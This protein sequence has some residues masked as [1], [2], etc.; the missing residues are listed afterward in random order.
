MLLTLLVI[1]GLIVVSTA[2]GSAVLAWVPG[3]GR[4]LL[5]ASPLGLAALVLWLSWIGLVVPPGS[6]HAL[7]LTVAAL[8][9]GLVLTWVRRHDRLLASARE[10]RWWGAGFGTGVLVIVPFLVVIERFGSARFVHLSSNHDGFFFVAIPEW[11]RTHTTFGGAGALSN[12]APLGTPLLGSTWDVFWSGSWRVGSDS[13]AA[14]VSRGSSV[15]PLDLW[16]PLTLV[17]LVVLVMAVGALCREFGL[18]LGS[19][20]LAMAVVGTSASALDHVADQHTPALLGLAL[21]LVLVAELARGTEGDDDGAS[22]IVVA[23]ALGGVAAVYSEVLTLALIPLVALVSVPWWRRRSIDLRWVLRAA[24]WSVL[25][26]GAAVARMLIGLARGNAPDGYESAYAATRGPGSI[27]RA[28]ARGGDAAPAI[29]QGSASRVAIVAFAAVAL[30]GLA[31]V[32]AVGPVR[33]WWIALVLSAVLWWALLGQVERSGYPQER[34]VEWAVPL[35]LVGAVMGWR[36]VGHRVSDS[37][38]LAACSPRVRAVAGASVLV[39]ACLV[40]AAPGAVRAVRIGESFGRW[41]DDE[42]LQAETWLAGRDP[43]GEDSVVLASEYLHNLWTPYVLRT[44]PEVAYVGIYPDYFALDHFGPMS[45]RRWLLLDAAAVDGAQLDDAAIV[46]RN[47]RFV[48]VDLSLAPATVEV[49]E[50]LDGRFAPDT[51]PVDVTFAD[52]MATCGR[53]VASHRCG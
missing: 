9:G 45:G 24:A 13:L 35:L 11:L 30:V 12:G 25:L 6:V 4:S 40:L 23:L 8:A 41:I 2:V 17:Y 14:L 22:P 28:L 26:G 38:R 29:A 42:F 50:G 48:L 43:L 36:E 15:D 34:L 49:V 47:G 52:G 10:L 33:R 18:G 5:P 44:L 51:G 46:E 21:L 20:V 53:A 37:A 27:L 32:C 1:F 31:A 19:S 3:S 7:A 16:F 39:L